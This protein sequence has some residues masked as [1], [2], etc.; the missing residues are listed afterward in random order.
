LTRTQHLDDL[1]E[2]ID[3]DFQRLQEIVAQDFT[4]M[5]ERQPLAR[6]DAGKNRFGPHPDRRA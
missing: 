2:R 5:D 3:A 4:R 6:D 1:R